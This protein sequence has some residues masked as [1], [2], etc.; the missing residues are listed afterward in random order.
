MSETR[1]EIREAVVLALVVGGISVLLSGFTAP[2]V[3]F[4]VAA[5]IVSWM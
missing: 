2:A 3:G 4:F 5:K 1:K